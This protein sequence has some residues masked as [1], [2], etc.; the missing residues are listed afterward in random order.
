MFH[1]F[2]MCLGY[3]HPFVFTTDTVTVVPSIGAPTVTTPTIATEMPSIGGSSPP[4]AAMPSAGVGVDTLGPSLSGGS[5]TTA[6]PTSLLATAPPNSISIEEVSEMW[7]A[8]ENV[9]VEAKGSVDLSTAQ[10]EVFNQTVSV[11]RPFFEAYFGDTLKSFQLGLTFLESKTVSVQVGDSGSEALVQSYFVADVSFLISSADMDVLIEFDQAKA[12]E[13][14]NTFYQGESRDVLL[15]LLYGKGIEV[16]S[17]EVYT[18]DLPSDDD[19][20]DDDETDSNGAS[21]PTPSPTE[22]PEQSSEK[23]E[24]TETKST[25]AALYAGIV[26][27]GVILVAI[28]A[29]IYSTRNSDRNFFKDA[30]ES[31][32]DS[33]YND[34]LG[35][36][37]G[38]K[39]LPV[40]SPRGNATAR[41][42]KSSMA[43]SDSRS[44]IK[45][46]A[47]T[48][49]KKKAAQQSSE[50]VSTLGSMRF[51]IERR[52][53]TINEGNVE[54]YDH[55]HRMENG[56][57]L[58]ASSASRVLTYHDAD[59]QGLVTNYP[60]F[61]I[62]HQN[63]YADTAWSV[64]GMTLEDE[65]LVERPRRW[66]DESSET[67]ISGL[68]DHHS[69]SNGS[70]RS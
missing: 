34:S 24:T 18:E 36:P 66:Q 61:D 3:S 40:L 14:V 45:P 9:T 42:G 7:V 54:D 19:A 26:S 17:L 67:G 4:V 27:G 31:V 10:G 39:I 25:N 48:L 12:T 63:P 21:P 58:V 16:E 22:D 68:P 46:A 30:L 41:T 6:V 20:T 56:P 59:I 35:G 5:D 15:K 2:E 44:R 62:Y 64:D 23:P 60:E 8:A 33:L 29:V 43:S 49:R 38:G 37:S 53:P 50:S 57:D 70:G 32:S 52:S 28:G 51:P 13:V 69:S 47:I 65:S 11:M 55:L 1:C